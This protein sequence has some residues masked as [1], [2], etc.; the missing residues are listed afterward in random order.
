MQGCVP[1]E[2]MRFL[3]W[4]NDVS[5]TIALIETCMMGVLSCTAASSQG[6]DGG[7]RPF[8]SRRNLDKD[9]PKC[10]RDEASA[11]E[12]CTE[13]ATAGLKTAVSDCAFGSVGAGC[14]LTGC[15]LSPGGVLGQAAAWTICVKQKAQDAF[16]Q[17]RQY[18]RN[19]CGTTGLCC[20]GE[21]VDT[22]I[23][24]GNCGRCGGDCPFAYGCG[25]PGIEIGM[26]MC[27]DGRCSRTSIP[28]PNKCII[29]STQCC[30][31]GGCR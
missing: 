18:C 26:Q 24:D 2:R 27:T 25:D 13:V 20:D 15:S 30:P 1:I 16:D 14:L 5:P 9:N 21:C 17:L 22:R 10:S 23:S 12:E 11:F 7:V 31:D 19:P 8:P 4:E 6:T 3:P 28:C 29:N